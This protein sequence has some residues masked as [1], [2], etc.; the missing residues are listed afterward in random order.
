ML[1]LRR[2]PDHTTLQHRCKKLRLADLEKMKRRLLDESGVEEEQI[3]SDSTDFSPGQAKPILSDPYGAGISALGEGGVC[4]GH[5]LAVHLGLAFGLGVG[6]RWGV[7]VWV[8]AGG[9][10]LWTLS[11]AA[12]GLGDDSRCWL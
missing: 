2:V 4:R 6:Q 9:A 10:S 12:Q 3:A 8:A 11:R 5:G 7:S 1:E